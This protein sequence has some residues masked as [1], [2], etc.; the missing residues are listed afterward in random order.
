LIGA[1]LANAFLYWLYK[2]SARFYRAA[3]SGKAMKEI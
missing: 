3:K 1:A 2:P